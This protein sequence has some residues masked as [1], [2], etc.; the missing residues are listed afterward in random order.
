M[1][2]VV[3]GGPPCQG[4]ST[5]DPGLAKSAECALESVR[6]RGGSHATSVLRARERAGILNSSQFRSF[7]RTTHRGG[8]L[9][10]YELEPP[11]VIDASR[12]GTA[13]RRRRAIIVGRLRGLPTVLD[14]TRETQSRSVRDAFANIPWVVDDAG[15]PAPARSMPFRDAVVPGPFCGLDLHVTRRF[16]RVSARRFAA[17]PPGGNRMDLPIDLQPVCWQRHRG[18]SGDVMGRLKWEEPSVTVRTEFFKPEKGRY[19]HPDQHRPITHLEAARLQG[20]RTN[21]NGAERRSHR[22][23]DR[24]RCSC[25]SRPRGLARSIREALH[26][27]DGHDT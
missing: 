10:S 8:R 4:F 16:T 12:Y 15:H 25:A 26:L 11:A 21:S 9:A 23:T 20:F 6:R 24:E 27:I 13:Q 2:D 1:A 5:R 18:G 17:I 14:R 22:A 7:R 19:L 3:M